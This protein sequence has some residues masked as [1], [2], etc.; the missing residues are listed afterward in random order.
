MSQE[1]LT[2]QNDVVTNELASQ[3]S[4][5]KEVSVR[6]ELPVFSASSWI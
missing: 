4:R 6:I 1:L 3:V 5:I 2:K